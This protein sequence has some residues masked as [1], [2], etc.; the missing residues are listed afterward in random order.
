MHTTFLGGG[1][2][3]RAEMDFVEQAV[4][5]ARATPGR[6][7]K[8]FW[9]REQDLRHDA[10]RPAA[11]C[12]VRGRLDDNGNLAAMDY[13]LVTQSVVA[14]YETRTPTPRGGDAAS[15]STV[16]EA[17]NPPVYPLQH[18]RLRFTPADLHVPAGYWRSV[19]HSWTTFFMESFVDE[20]A[21]A[22][23]IDPLDYRRR[24]MADRPRHRRVLDT[25]AKLSAD[26]PGD[27]TGYALAESHGSVVAHAIAVTAPA[28]VFAAVTRVICVVDCG[29]V[30]HPDNVVAQLES[31]VVDGLSAALYGEVNFSAGQALTN[32]IHA[33]TGERLR[34]LPV[35]GAGYS[36]GG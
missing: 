13:T 30:V 11:A 2:G 8:L 21:L 18:L 29:P 17:V 26:L 16:A 23:D 20:A 3:R 36:A 12:R 35:R 4:S 24:L 15:D 33:A 7:V 10:F 27:G 14:S 6:P 19:A 34:H 22:A 32:A 25:L 5:A 9:S 31:S 1:F 28:G